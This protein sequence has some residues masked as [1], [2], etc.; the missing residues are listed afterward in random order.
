MKG[1]KEL[2]KVPVEDARAFKVALNYQG[3]VL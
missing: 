1:T 2:I 3:I